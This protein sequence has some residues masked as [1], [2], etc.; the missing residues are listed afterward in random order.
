MKIYIKKNM[1]RIIL[2]FYIILLINCEIPID[3]T[4]YYLIVRMGLN[5]VN[6]S[7][8]L[9][10]KYDVFN[11]N[12]TN[13]Y[14]ETLNNY[15]N[16]HTIIEISKLFSANGKGLDDLGNELECR[17]NILNS[18]YYFVVFR[19]KNANMKNTFS[20][21]L[22]R[23]YTFWGFCFPTYCIDL[24]NNVFKKMN[25][26]DIYIYLTFTNLNIKTYYDKGTDDGNNNGIYSIFMLIILVILGIKFLFG[27]ICQ[28]IFDKG[29]TY[30]GYKQFME[31]RQKNSISGEQD[32]SQFDN[33][34]NN[35][36]ENEENMLGEYNPNHD[37]EPFFPMRLR[38]MKYFDLWDNLNILFS[39]RNRYYDDKNL[40]YINFSKSVI[41]IYF[42]FTKTI[43]ML[44]ELPN[45][46]FLNEKFYRGRAFWV[47]YKR[48]VNAINFWI[49]LEAATFSYKVMKFIKHKTYKNQMS[50]AK[51][52]IK[53]MVFFIPKIISFIII[54]FLV[55]YNSDNLSI[56]I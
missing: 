8:F 32:F 51:A 39:Y 47:I 14:I 10:K 54:Y 46:D 3:F 29:Y 44:F 53:F 18:K 35:N 41:I 12:L 56:D 4:K 19:Q 2:I 11:P 55:Y 9:D 26:S 37:Y 22:N 52:I 16:D 48:A 7:T 45:P 33:N 15:Q 49:I 43:K 1:F 24:A 42:L 36:M 30:R 20:Y 50:L 13:C 23:S 25:H 28:L 6:I 34:D 21:F 40:A 17:N 38:L 27:L 5:L 31:R